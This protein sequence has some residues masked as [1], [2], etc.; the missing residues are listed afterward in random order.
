MICRDCG[1]EIN[2]RR[3]HVLDDICI[4]N[5][6]WANQ[7]FQTPIFTVYVCSVCGRLYHK[8]SEIKKDDGTY[9]YWD[10]K[11]NRTYWRPLVP[12]PR[13]LLAI[14][15][16][17]LEK[18]P[19]LEPQE[20]FLQEPGKAAPLSYLLWAVM[21]IWNMEDPKAGRWLGWLLA[22]IEFHGFWDNIR[23]RELVRS[24]VKK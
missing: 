21:L 20:E 11:N 23:S 8:N 15:A 9:F 19:Y 14:K 5:I 3:P 16:A 7:G 4:S 6:V 17:L 2:M 24:D 13:T 18:D 10:E 1:G 22:Q 12:Y